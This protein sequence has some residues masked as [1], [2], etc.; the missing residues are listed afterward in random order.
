MFLSAGLGWGG[1]CFGKDTAALIAAA[2]D[3]GYRTRLFEAAVAVNLNQR[4]HVIDLLLRHFHTLRG[5]RVA[6]LGITFKPGTD[7][8]RDSPAL[9]VICRLVDR[10]C[11]ISAHDPAVT[12]LPTI[13]RSVST[14]IHTM[15]HMEPTPWSSQPMA[16]ISPLDLHRLNAGAPSALLLI[17]GIS[18]TRK[19]LRG[20]TPL[21]GSWEGRPQDSRPSGSPSGGLK[22]APDRHMIE[23]HQVF[24]RL[25]AW[26]EHKG[27]SHVVM[28]RTP[29]KSLGLEFDWPCGTGSH[30]W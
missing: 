2:K 13:P 3:Y 26:A 15:Q 17:R 8:F 1:S 25:S 6:V 5:V 29:L 14:T 9:D 30:F 7:D 28:P 20:G 23:H 18:S 10:G 4:G 12:A 16:A 11:F 22:P 21:P 24:F 27:T 19:G